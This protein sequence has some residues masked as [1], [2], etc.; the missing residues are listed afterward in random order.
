MAPHHSVRAMDRHRKVSPSSP[1]QTPTEDT[2]SAASK[3]EKKKVRKSPAK[4]KSSPKS[5]KKKRCVNL[6][7]KRKAAP[8]GKQPKI[9]PTTLPRV[10]EA[11]LVRKSQKKKMPPPSHLLPCSRAQT[12]ISSSTPGPTKACKHV[13]SNKS[14]SWKRQSAPQPLHQHE[15]SLWRLRLHHRAHHRITRPGKEQSQEDGRHGL[16]ATGRSA[17]FRLAHPEEQPLQA[18]LRWRKLTCLAHPDMKPPQD[19]RT[20]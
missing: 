12:K 3:S 18:M 1:A 7:P 16:K 20:V 13:T 8:K 19:H 15:Q 10:A 6:P 14:G 11:N 9:P 4:K 2:Q 17:R 5:E